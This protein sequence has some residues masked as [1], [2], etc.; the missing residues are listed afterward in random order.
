V[1]DRHDPLAEFLTGEIRAGAMPGAAWWVGDDA[2]ALSHGVVGRA[3]LVPRPEPAR[4]STPYDL[5]SLTKPLATALLALLL[6]LDLGK[7]LG[8]LFPPL[9]AGPYGDATLE[10]AG[11]HRARL[12]AWLPLYAWGSSP[13][14]YVAAI[15]RA[16]PVAE[17]STVYSDLGYLL[18]GFA[19]ATAAGRPLDRLFDERIAEP[20][21]LR[22]TGFPGTGSRF[23]DAAA[24]ERGN[25]YERRLAGGGASTYAF[26]T[27]L[28]RGHV[29]DG[30]AWGLGGIA[31]HAGLFGVA[32]DVATIAR[33]LLEPARLGVT[34]ETLA[35][36]WDAG[37]APG[38]RTFG[39]LHARDAESV[40]QVLPD[41]AIGHFGFTGTS[42]WIDR[43]RPRVY[44]LLTNRVHP[45]VPGI[46]FTR[47]RRG[48]HER[49]ASL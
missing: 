5:A 39:F 2:R 35:P 33:A 10:D 13:A 24:T 21:A 37:D 17:G 15:A 25:A 6:R 18:L 26:R 49:A 42:L 48:F 44:V 22:R 38:G 40:R 8:A 23:A 9:A 3:V 31:G 29:H 45:D 41:A 12:P 46:D 34:A 1:S 30:N 7:R 32:A 27:A 16:T 36:M 28:I 19:V 47:T 43:S 14:A 11:K 4:G 20:L